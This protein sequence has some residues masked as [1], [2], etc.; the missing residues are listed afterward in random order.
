MASPKHQLS[1]WLLL[2]KRGWCSECRYAEGLPD[3]SCYNIPK[4]EINIPNNQK[5]YQ[6]NTKCTKKYTKW[7]QNM[8]NGNKIDQHLQLQNPP[9]LTQIGI[10]GLK[11]GYLATLVRSYY[12]LMYSHAA[13]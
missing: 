2:Q 9:K 3:F 4:R 11:I 5:M 13:G 7:P 1:N 8:P 6:I 10:L 12:K